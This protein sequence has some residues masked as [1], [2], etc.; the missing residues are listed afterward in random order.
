M[1][2]INK[3]RNE[4]CTSQYYICTHLRKGMSSLTQAIAIVMKGSVHNSMSKM[5][6]GIS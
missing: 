6:T 5:F 3:E 2:Y 4:N 1:L